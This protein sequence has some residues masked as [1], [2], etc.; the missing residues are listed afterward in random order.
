VADDDANQTMVA[1]SEASG[2]ETDAQEK[3]GAD[4]RAH[5]RLKPHELGALEARF[6]SGAD[7]RLVDLSRGGAQ[8]ETDRRFLPNSSIA[9]RLVTPDGPFVVNGRVVRSR[10]VRLEQG[11]L[12]YNVA[13]AF[14]E[15]LKYAIEVPPSGAPVSTTSP[16]A[17]EAGIAVPTPIRL[18]GGP[19]EL[20]SAADAALSAEPPAELPTLALPSFASLVQEDGSAEASSPADTEVTRI[21]DEAPSDVTQA[22]PAVFDAN[23]F[24]ASPLVTVTATV[25]QTRDE[26]RDMFNG[27]DW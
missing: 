17:P 21:P 15:A 18:E 5:P 4:R 22:Q 11:G 23:V 7:I 3:T 10:I 12:G 9:L 8:F 14:A 13:V 19:V 2:M 16:E 27:N 25:S 1:P 24:D 26:L 20:T 6:A